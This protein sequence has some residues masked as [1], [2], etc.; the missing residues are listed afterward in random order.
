MKGRAD[1]LREV[2]ADAKHSRPDPSQFAPG[3]MT[4]RILQGKCWKFFSELWLE[5]EVLLSDQEQNSVHLA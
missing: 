1:V 3:T 5:T 4:N 2:A